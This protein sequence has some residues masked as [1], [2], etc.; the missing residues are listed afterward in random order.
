MTVVPSLRLL[1]Q[2]RREA[3]LVRAFAE[4]E[5]FRYSEESGGFR[6]GRL[7]SGLVVRLASEN[8]GGG[9]RR[10]QGELVGLGIKAPVQAPKARAHAERWVGSVAANVSTSC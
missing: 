8:P 4:L 2:A 3:A 6:G 7:L 9:Y 5:T 10:I 1:V